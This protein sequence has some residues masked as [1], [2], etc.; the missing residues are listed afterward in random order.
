MK[1]LALGISILLISINLSGQINYDTLM[2]KMNR[3]SDPYNQL[4][5]YNEA[6]D[7][8]TSSEDYIV[9]LKDSLYTIEQSLMGMIN[10]LRYLGN[11][12]RED[13]ATFGD[14][15]EFCKEIESEYIK[16]QIDSSN[17]NLESVEILGVMCDVL[18]LWTPTSYTKYY[19]SEQYKLDYPQFY[20]N[21][22]ETLYECTKLTNSLP[23][24]CEFENFRMMG[25]TK[26]V[27]MKY[28]LECKELPTKI[29]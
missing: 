26:I 21:E 28:I 19:Y 8:E 7:K 12:K 29:K 18:E 4:G 16:L 17:V 11:G 27:N 25:E 5:M 13:C 2:Y 22:I 1:T 24:K 3:S 15:E 10:K 6:F 23:I 14:S 20:E 9:I